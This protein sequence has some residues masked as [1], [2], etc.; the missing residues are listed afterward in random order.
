MSFPLENTFSTYLGWLV[1]EGAPITL[2]APSEEE[3]KAARLQLARIGIDA[4]A[5]ASTGLIEALLDG[6]A[7][8]SYPVTTFARLS[9]LGEVALVDVRLDDEWRSGHIE[10]SL[11]IPLHELERRRDTLPSGPIAVHC[12]SGYRAGIAASILR[13]AGRDVV[14]V[15]DEWS[16]AEKAMPTRIEEEVPA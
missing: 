7:R 15:D 14:L 1:P 10:G 3:L 5:G 13:R 9:G 16:N 12:A 11:H 8:D 6:T 2:V 4:L